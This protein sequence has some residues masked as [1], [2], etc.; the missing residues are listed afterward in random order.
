MVVVTLLP[1]GPWP[2][3]LVLVVAALVAVW[4]NP[5]SRSVPGESRA[6][7]WRLTAMVVLLGVASLRPAVP[8]DEV[9]ASAANL[10][11]YFVVDTTSSIIAE[12]Y[13]DE[14]PRIAGVESDIAAIT[15]ALPGAR[16]A[17]ITFDQATRVRLPLTTD[18]NALDAALETLLPEPSEYSQ[19]SS[20]SAADERLGRMLQQAEER[21]PDRG[22]VVFYLGDGEQTAPEPAAPFTVDRRLIDGGAVLGYGTREGGRM[23]STRS[24]FD[25]TTA[26]I[27]DPATGEDARSVIDEGNLRGIGDQLGLPYVHRESGDAID[28]VVAGVDLERFGTSEELEQQ[29]VRVPDG[30]LLAVADR[31]RRTRR[32]GAG[33][34]PHRPRPDPTAQGGAAVSAGPGPERSRRRPSGEGVELLFDDPDMPDSAH[35]RDTAAGVGSPQLAATRGARH[36]ARRRGRRD[37]GW[38]K[39]PRLP[40][41]AQQRRRRRRLLLGSLPVVVLLVLVALRLLS[42][43][44]VAS[45]TLAA[46]QAGDRA[47]T[48]EWG[49]RQG[50][51]NIVEQFRSPFAIGDAHVLTGSFEQARPWFELS[52]E[53]VPKGGIDECKV[54]V[55]LGLTYEALGDA[56][57]AKERTAEWRQFYEKGIQ[58]TSQRPPL[59]DAPEGQQTGEQLQQTQQRLEDKSA[60]PKPE[61]GETPPEQPG[62]APGEQPTPKPEPTPDPDNTPSQEQQ[63]F[64]Q[65]QQRQ[66]TVERNQQLGEDDR[67]STGGDGPVYPKPW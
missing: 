36:T 53:Q 33:S 46:Y 56:A 28:P 20:I 52:L 9:N 50:W 14:R 40:M 32:V 41:T 44:L 64:L 49:E 63:D 65:E 48:Q 11:V 8:G 15:Q 27:L 43:N 29:R 62:N 2:V 6:T 3:L 22:R 57:K 66:N 47:T 24:R 35:T 19:G 17:V 55:N 13:G 39:G 51:V 37:E 31:C 5:T 34:E 45:Q 25:S 7:H 67:N 30:A 21:A 10:N 60:D 23:K 12:D 4:W 26:Y 54:R 42:L 1:I 58:T 16:Y 61:P 18:S 59:C 38:E